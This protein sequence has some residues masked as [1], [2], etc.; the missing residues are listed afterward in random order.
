MDLFVYTGPQNI[1]ISQQISNNSEVVLFYDDRCF[2]PVKRG[3]QF[4]VNLRGN[5]SCG[6]FVLITPCYKS[7]LDNSYDTQTDDYGNIH[8]CL[9]H[10]WILMIGMIQTNQ[11]DFM[12][13]VYR[14]KAF[15][16]FE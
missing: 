3:L 4:T 1:S 15:Q 14:K 7:D 16:S 13:Y 11:R 9:I 10:T 5:I 8:S 2:D 12:V 6:I